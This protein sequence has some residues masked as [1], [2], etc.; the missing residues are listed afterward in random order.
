M[1]IEKTTEKGHV[2]NHSLIRK[3]HNIQKKE[4]EYS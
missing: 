2:I 4:R 3:K 1:M